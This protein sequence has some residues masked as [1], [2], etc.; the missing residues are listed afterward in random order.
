[1]FHSGA[2]RPVSMHSVLVTGS[3]PPGASSSSAALN[4]WVPVADVCP[5]LHGVHIASDFPFDSTS[6]DR[7]EKTA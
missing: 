4:R 3:P 6:H 1:M 7:Q 2:H 5:R